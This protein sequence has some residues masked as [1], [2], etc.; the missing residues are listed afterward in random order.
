MDKII[1]ATNNIHKLAEVRQIIGQKLNILSLEDAGITADIPEDHQTLDENAVQKAQ[2]IFKKTGI[3]CFADDTGLEVEALNGLPG[4]YSARYAGEAK[5]SSDN[6]N[7]LLEE[8]KNSENRRAQF[9]CVIAFVSDKETKL[10]EGVVKGQITRKPSGNGGFGYDPVFIPEGYSST[11]A[12]LKP[13]I[14]NSI[15]HRA[16]AAAKLAGYLKNKIL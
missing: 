10:F 3:A 5:R 7:K 16:V 4:V 15:S 9:R 13:E 11:F 6:V 1:F 2:F 14:K 8:L 12:E